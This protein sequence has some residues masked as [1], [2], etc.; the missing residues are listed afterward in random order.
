MRRFLVVMCIL[1][2]LGQAA[3]A[4]TLEQ[5]LA[6]KVITDYQLDPDKVRITL[7]RSDLEQIEIDGFAIEAYPAT[8]SDPRG[9]FPMRVELFRDGAR[10]EKGSVSLDVRVFADLPVP[11]QNIKRHEM[12]TADLFKYKRFDITSI[13]EKLLTETAQFE[14]C[15][16]KQNLAADRYI[17][18]RRVEKL[19]DVE[20][21]NTV[22]IVGY[23]DLFEIRARGLALQ[24]GV[25]GESIKVKNVDSRKILIGKITAPGVVEIAI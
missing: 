8:Q 22:T 18:L 23:S 5:Y 24:N 20:N 4:E 14:G 17:P 6:E 10:V 13:T 7:V 19:P 12:L 1:G 16:A 3:L 2:L 25:I 11:V 21:G 9:R 15:R